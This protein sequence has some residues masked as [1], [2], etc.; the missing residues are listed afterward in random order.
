MTARLPGCCIWGMEV[1]LVTGDWNSEEG[2]EEGRETYSRCWSPY[3]TDEETET[4]RAELNVI[5]QQRS[6]SVFPL[7]FPALEGGGGALAFSPGPGAQQP[8]P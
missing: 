7:G 5:F 1:P 8:P 3:L 6:Q 4:L 2:W